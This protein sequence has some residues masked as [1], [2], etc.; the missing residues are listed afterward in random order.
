MK[1]HWWLCAMIGFMFGSIITLVFWSFPQLSLQV[2]E[3]HAISG[4]TES[5]L[6]RIEARQ[7]VTKMLIEQIEKAHAK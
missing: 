5:R 2:D 7:E 3:I 1:T 6:K 4:D